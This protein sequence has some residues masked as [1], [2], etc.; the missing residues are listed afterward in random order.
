[1]RIAIV[2]TYPIYRGFIP[3]EEWLTE[4]NRER[5]LTGQLA[6]MGHEVEIWAVGETAQT[7]D[8]VNHPFKIRIFKPDNSQQHERK[9]YSDTLVSHAQKFNADLVILK[10]VDG[11]VGIRLLEKYILRH[12]RPYIF[13]IG[14]TVYTKHVPTAEIVF[15]ETEAQRKILQS[16]GRY[17][18]RKRVTPEKLIRLPKLIEIDLFCPDAKA[19]K[20]WDI[21]VVG[22]LM[23]RY[24]NYSALG[25]LSKHFKV[26]VIGDGPDARHLQTLYPGV[27]WLGHIPN[28][29]VPGYLNRAHLFMHPGFKDY[30][31][32][33]LAEAMSC[34]IPCIAFEKAIAPDV[35]PVGCGLRIPDKN[36]IPLIRE[37]LQ[38]TSPLREMGQ[39]AREF[40]LEHIGKI[41]CQK[42]LEE[43]SR[44]LPSNLRINN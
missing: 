21:L 8:D 18:W 25:E 41:P 15:Y 38:S 1:M 13:I 3:Q 14:G 17:F 12:R 35:L 20:E 11:G 43:M 32:R 33:V 31:P 42:A 6:R 10:G 7:T 26:A 9:H 16:P 24:K 44:R 5:C 34:G 39:K 28:H 22:R 4:P 36:Y 23:R 29:L 27:E 30:Y 37:T 40:A 19:S 2:F